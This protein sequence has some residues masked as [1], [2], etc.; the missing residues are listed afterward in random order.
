MAET[1]LVIAEQR[2]GK[3]NRVSLETVAGA[4]ALAK[5]TGWTVEAAVVGGEGIGSGAAAE[6]GQNRAGQ[7][8]RDRER[9]AGELHSGRLCK[10]AESVHRRPPAQAGAAAAHL[11]GTRFCPR[12][13]CEAG[14]GAGERR[15]GLSIRGRKTDLHAADVP[16]KIR[17]RCFHG[18]RW[19]VVCQLPERRL[20][21]R[22]GRSW[23]C[24]RG[25]GER[26]DGRRS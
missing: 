13:R 8:L 20:S 3:L 11:P 1:I 16:G 10:R 6:T 15:G 9:I 21:R 5:Q 19:A 26:H 7:G 23:R 4:Q 14:L 24:S 2:E 22:S 12:A 18:G 17:C 25:N